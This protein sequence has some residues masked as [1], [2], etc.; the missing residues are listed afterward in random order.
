MTTTWEDIR[1][2]VFKFCSDFGADQQAAQI[3]VLTVF[4]FDAH[5]EEKALPTGDIIGPWQL[6]ADIV[7]DAL[8]NVTG[9][10]G[11]CTQTDP[12]LFKLEKM[13]GALLER[14]KPRQ[15]IPLVDAD[16]GVAYGR[17]TVCSGTSLSPVA[18]AQ[19]RP[20]KFVHF[21]LKADQSI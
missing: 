17:L 6:S 3:S 9:M 19:Q 15:A 16:T 1:A 5:V 12:N 20:L 8:I 13:A 18:Q 10:I 4:N 21:T 7:N 2:S 11:L 14:M